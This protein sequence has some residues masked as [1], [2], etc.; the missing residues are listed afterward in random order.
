[1]K[2]YDDGA[3]KELLFLI[4]ETSV[5][6]ENVTMD[7]VQKHSNKNNSCL[8]PGKNTLMQNRLMLN[9]LVHIVPVVL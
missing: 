8:F 9:R 2:V 5:S 3:L 6:N 7:I 4:S 1:M